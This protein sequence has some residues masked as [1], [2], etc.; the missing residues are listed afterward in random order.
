MDARPGDAGA[1]RR[2]AHRPY[3][4]D[5][6]TT[7]DGLPQSSVTSITQTRD[8]YLWLGTFSGL[9]NMEQRVRSLGGEFTVES[10]A[11]GGTRIELRMKLT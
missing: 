4:I 2:P 6:W 1:R 10:R 5:T 3:A 11:G 9:T 7:A 8:G